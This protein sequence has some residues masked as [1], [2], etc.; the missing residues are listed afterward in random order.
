MATNRTTYKLTG[1][2]IGLFFFGTVPTAVFAV[3]IWNIYPYWL[4]MLLA[5][6]FALWFGFCTYAFVREIRQTPREKQEVENF[7]KLKPV[8]ESGQ[9]LVYESHVI[10]DNE[11]RKELNKAFLR[12]LPALII[13]LIVPGLLGVF[14]SYWILLICL[15]P[16]GLATA[17]WYTI[18][19]MKNRNRKVI[20]RGVITNRPYHRGEEIGDSQHFLMIGDKRVKVEEG[21]YDQYI[22]GDIIELHYVGW[23]KGDTM[24]TS[25]SAFT[26]HR[27]LSPAEFSEWVKD[28]AETPVPV[29]G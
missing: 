25:G 19:V 14:L 16:I 27:K 22:V 18:R 5:A 2:A 12:P 26:R 11:D 9:Q 6:F 24:S 23:L 21:L 8:V 20:I 10:L 15:A 13:F 28:F 17:S 3:V 4:W 7:E 1:T 29:V